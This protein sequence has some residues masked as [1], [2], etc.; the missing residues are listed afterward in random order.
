MTSVPKELRTSAKPVVAS[1]KNMKKAHDDELTESDDDLALKAVVANQATA[2]A[3][4]QETQI[5]L[6]RFLER[7]LPSQQLCDQ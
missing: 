6:L 4:K 7:D 5:P 3:A 2:Q 1:T